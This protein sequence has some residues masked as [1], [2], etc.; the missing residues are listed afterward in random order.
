MNILSSLI[1]YDLTLFF[2]ITRFGASTTKILSPKQSQF[3]A[4]LKPQEALNMSL[5]NVHI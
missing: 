4:P 2:P 1:L 3:K 5:Q